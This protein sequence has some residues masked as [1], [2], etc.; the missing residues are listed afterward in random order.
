MDKKI[1]ITIHL[2]DQGIQLGFFVA[3]MLYYKKAF[4]CIS[5]GY[6]AK[7]FQGRHR[8]LYIHMVRL[9]LQRHLVGIDWC[10]VKICWG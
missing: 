6:R 3:Q 5:C 9:T 1:G 7:V 4:I 2:L 10:A 8:T